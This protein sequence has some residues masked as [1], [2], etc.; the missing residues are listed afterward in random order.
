MYFYEILESN[1]QHKKKQLTEALSREELQNN[2]YYELGAEKI[3]LRHIHNLRKSKDHAD[4][5]KKKRLEFLPTMY[6]LEGSL[7]NDQKV[8][9]EKAR[10]DNETKLSIE[11]IKAL[12]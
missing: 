12:Q 1:Y 8:D 11:R 10:M 4:R 6:G 3:T 7:T 9:L 2:D 5:E